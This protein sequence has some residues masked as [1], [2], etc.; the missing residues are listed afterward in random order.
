MINDPTLSSI[1]GTRVM[2]AVL[3]QTPVLPAVTY[4]TVNSKYSSYDTASKAVTSIRTKIDVS[5]WG[6]TNQDAQYGIE[7]I[8]KMF[9]LFQGTLSDGTEVLYTDAASIPD[10]Y[11]EDTRYFRASVTLTFVHKV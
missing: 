7:A 9:A 2:P 10:M 4:S 8:K 11:E 6:L 1:V 5:C 3:P